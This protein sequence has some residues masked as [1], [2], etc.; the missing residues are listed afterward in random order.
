MSSTIPSKTRKQKHCDWVFNF[1]TRYASSDDSQSG[2]EPDDQELATAKIGASRLPIN[3]LDLSTR[4]EHVAYKPNPFSIAKINAAYRPTSTNFPSSSSSFPEYA[5]I[6]PVKASHHDA[7][8][9]SKTSQSRAFAPAQLLPDM[10]QNQPKC[11]ENRLSGFSSFSSPGHP[12]DDVPLGYDSRI[13]YTQTYSSPIQLA[14]KSPFRSCSTVAQPFSR[15]TME[16]GFV[17]PFLKPFDAKRV[18]E[19]FVL[20]C[21]LFLFSI[22][23]RCIRAFVSYCQDQ[24]SM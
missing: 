1:R 19:R 6:L 15:Q 16:T 7:Q 8:T 5:Y 20:S 9:L 2:S 13:L 14:R 23:R 22:S 17:P 11:T 3:D 4:E 10:L 18:S 21:V 24:R 12:Y